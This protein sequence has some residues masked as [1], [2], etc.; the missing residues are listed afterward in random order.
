MTKVMSKPN[1]WRAAPRDPHALDMRKR[2]FSAFAVHGLRD[3]AMERFV[4]R[5]LISARL[6]LKKPYLIILAAGSTRRTDRCCR[7]IDDV[8]EAFHGLELRT[9]TETGAKCCRRCA[10]AHS[11]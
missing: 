5:L 10:A 1:A 4:A 2:E 9:D 7:S 8:V 11:D 6:P 3:P